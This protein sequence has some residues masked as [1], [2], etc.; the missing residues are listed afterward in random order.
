MHYKFSELPSPANCGI[1]SEGEDDGGGK[2][3]QGERTAQ[4][5]IFSQLGW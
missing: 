2:S 4:F 5:F 3:P 1:L